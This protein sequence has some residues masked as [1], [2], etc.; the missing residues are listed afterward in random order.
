M[1]GKIFRKQKKN[2]QDLSREE[3]MRKIRKQRKRI[4]K[5]G[6]INGQRGEQNHFNQV[7][8]SVRP[9]GR[10]DLRIY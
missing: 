9:L 3:I 8:L 2:Q 10:Q 6:T 4:R 1:T 5:M 7:H